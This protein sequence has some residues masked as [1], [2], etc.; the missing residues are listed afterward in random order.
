MNQP[1]GPKERLFGL[2]DRIPFIKETADPVVATVLALLLLLAIVGISIPGQIFPHDNAA[3][4]HVMQMAGGLVVVFGAYYATVNLR[5]VRAQ[6]YLDRL[7]TVIEQVGSP[8]EPVRLGSIRLLQSAALE[9]PALPS[10]SMTAGAVAARQ[11][12]IRE[13]LDAISGEGDTPAARLA[14]RVITEMYEEDADWV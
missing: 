13:V 1:Q 8:S 4:S 6:R 7:S 3:R 14:A 5:E 12:A 11:K 10:D 2:C 9:K